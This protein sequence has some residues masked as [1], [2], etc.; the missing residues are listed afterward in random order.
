LYSRIGQYKDVVIVR[1]HVEEPAEEALAVSAD[2]P[3]AEA[4]AA[5]QD[6]PGRPETAARA[7]TPAELADLES[8]PLGKWFANGWFPACT[9]AGFRPTREQ[10]VEAAKQVLNI[11][12]RLCPGDFRKLVRKAREVHA[13]GWTRGGQKGLDRKNNDYSELFASAI[14][15]SVELW[16]QGQSNCGDKPG[17]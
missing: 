15:R 16:R 1:E 10:D 8:G 6:A 9:E 5:V 17:G 2:V 4:P 11:A 14:P 12:P 13:P 3:A 7:I